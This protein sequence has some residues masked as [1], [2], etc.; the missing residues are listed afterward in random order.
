MKVLSWNVNGLRAAHK[1]GF[2][3][4]LSLEAPDILC[5]QETKAQE[6]QLPLELKEI[7]GYHSFFVSGERKGYSG[8]GL[9][10]KIKPNLVAESLGMAGYESEGRVVLADYEDFLLLNV[11]FPNGKASPERLAY[12]LGFY[13]A[14]REQTKRLLDLGKK[15]VVCGDL[16]T[17]HQAIDLARP[18]ENEKF[19]G[20]LPQERAWIDGFLADGFFDTFRSFHGEGDHY[21]WWDQKTRARDRN[22]GWRIDYFFAS[23]N[24]KE[25][26][27]SAF[28][29][30][31]VM[32]SDH[33]P[34][35]IEIK[36]N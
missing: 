32:G 7:P 8:V 26:I 16:N 15:V 19:S 22:V 29:L 25:R 36:D 28:H 27:S 20:F 9:Y 18:K 13:Q 23:E 35:G 31:E 11:Y 17:A 24:L 6:N 14:F 1:K 2:L 30:P 33:C 12:K 4:W 34:L 3:D 10:S 21:T 5:L